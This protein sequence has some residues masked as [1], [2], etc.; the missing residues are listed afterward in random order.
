MAKEGLLRAGNATRATL[1]RSQLC[2]GETGVSNCGR[3]DLFALR[4][5]HWRTPVHRYVGTLACDCLIAE[6]LQ[7]ANEL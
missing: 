3:K 1:D 6:S 2:T 4:I 7:G 5:N